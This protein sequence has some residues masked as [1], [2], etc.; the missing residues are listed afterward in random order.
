MAN[1]RC[2][3]LLEAADVEVLDVLAL[4]RLRI[5]DCGWVEHPDELGERLTLTVVRRGARQQQGIRARRQEAGE[6]VSKRRA[7]RHVVALIDH[8]RVP[9]DSLEVMP[10]LPGIL[11]R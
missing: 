2:Y 3:V 6:T 9:V 10:V 4:V 8:D 7:V 1:L 11:Q 5:G